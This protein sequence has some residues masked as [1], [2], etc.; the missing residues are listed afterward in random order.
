M[1]GRALAATFGLLASLAL[2]EA[3]ARIAGYAPRETAADSQ[4][5]PLRHD[6]DA[7]LG[8]VPSPGTYH[9]RPGGGDEPEVEVNVRPDRARA[10]SSLDPGSRADVVTLGGS[11]T[12]GQDVGDADTWSW[13]LQERFPGLRVSNLAGNAYGTLQSLVRLEQYEARAVA[14]LRV[15]IYGFFDHHQARNVASWGWLVNLEKGNTRGAFEV[16]YALLDEEGQ[17]VRASEPA[18]W[19]RLPLRSTL[20]LVPLLERG[21]VVWRWREREGMGGPVTRAL[22]LEMAGTARRAGGHLLVAGLS[23]NPAARDSYTAFLKA[24]RIPVVDCDDPRIATRAWRARG[25]T[26]HPN[27]LA[28]SHWAECIARRLAPMLQ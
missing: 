16:P 22:L 27:E 15:A 12:F 25:G 7:D 4:Q 14:P 8:W 5:P 23:W 26:G 24:A 21:L 9:Y 2:A 28:H 3:G 11:Y 10:T 13:K 17:L 1:W 18:T 20:A 19:P 6:R